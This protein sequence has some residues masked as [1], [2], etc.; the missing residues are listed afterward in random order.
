MPSLTDGTLLQPWGSVDTR[1]NLARS[2]SA[3]AWKTFPQ[4][5]FTWISLPRAVAYPPLPPPPVPHISAS[6]RTGLH[7]RQ[8]SRFNTKFRCL[9]VSQKFNSCYSRRCES[10]NDVLNKKIKIRPHTA[11]HQT[12]WVLPGM[13]SAQSI[14]YDSAAEK[15]SRVLEWDL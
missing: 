8:D 5:K 13:C 7:F 15:L 12:E 2:H 14:L 1:V 6:V 10:E 4:G 3:T 9:S 11:R